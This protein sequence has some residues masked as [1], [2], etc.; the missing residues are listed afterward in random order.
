ME[1]DSSAACLMLSE[2]RN[3][4]DYLTKKLAATS[5]P[6]IKIMLE[7]MIE[8]TKTYT[9]EELRCDAIVLATA[10]NPLFRLS[11][12]KAWYPNQYSC[13]QLLLNTQFMQQ[14]NNIEANANRISTLSSESEDTRTQPKS[15]QLHCQV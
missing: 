7:Q 12:F 4:K 9:D 13:V 14:K 5:K 6:E 11:M 8:K 2:Y 10:L 1:G 15:S 3:L